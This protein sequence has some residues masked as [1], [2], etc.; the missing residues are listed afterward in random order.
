MKDTQILS[1]LQ[2]EIIKAVDDVL[3]I[4]Y[5]GKNQPS[6]SDS[7]WWEIIYIPSNV[8]DEFW[9]SEKTYRGIF[10]LL[11][12]WPQDNAGIYGPVEEATRVANSFKKGLQITDDDITITITDNPDITGVV[13][14]L[15]NLIIPLTIKYNCFIV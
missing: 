12:H 9:G 11:L 2:K 5:L 4:K 8:S 6:V 7:K 1:L 10:R 3:P 13:E 14:D 15:P